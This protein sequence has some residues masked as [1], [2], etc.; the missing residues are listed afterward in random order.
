MRAMP[1]IRA[2]DEGCACPAC[3]RYSR[4][5]LHHLVRANEILGSMLLTEHNLRYYGGLMR[6]CAAR[7]RRARSAI[8]PPLCRD[9]ARG[10]IPPL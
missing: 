8:S 4:A 2:A 10:D 5:Y 3:T 1:T 6:A 9:Q 7:S